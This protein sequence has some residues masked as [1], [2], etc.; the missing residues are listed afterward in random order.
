VGFALV[1]AAIWGIEANNTPSAVRSPSPDRRRPNV[2]LI[3]IEAMAPGHCS[4]YGYERD[5]TPFL[6]EL[7]SES[8]VFE[9]AYSTSSWTRPSIASIFTGLYPSQ[10][11]TLHIKDTLAGGLLTLAEIL[12]ADGYVTAGFCTNSVVADKQ[13]NYCQGFDTYE[14]VRSAHF[15]AFLPVL[16]EWF[17]G[18]PQQPFFLFMHVF[19][20]HCPYNAPGEFRDMYAEGYSGRLAEIDDL[21]FKELAELKP[22]TAEEAEYVTARYDA[23]IAYTDHV[24]RQFAQLFKDRGLWDRS[25]VILTADHGEAMNERGKWG[26]RHRLYP[27]QIHVPLVMK[28]P[29]GA[30]GGNRIRGLASGIDLLPTALRVADLTVPE[31]VQGIDLLDNLA[32][33]TTGRRYCYSEFRAG[34]GEERTRGDSLAFLD[35]DYHYIVSQREGSVPKEVLFDRRADPMAEH[36]LSAERPAVVDQYSRDLARIRESLAPVV[37]REQASPDEET[38]KALRDLGYM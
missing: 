8:L 35:D 26:H 18:R 9:E 5:T 24:M 7:A 2:V 34:P 29:G 17:A 10:H 25:F 15:D 30:H 3:I 32:T 27:E 36:D 11:G 4:L 16:S 23:E 1:I 37:A 14:R 6:R 20:P 33:G 19:D 31:G 13:F 38:L 21:A 12:Q 22:F 28:L